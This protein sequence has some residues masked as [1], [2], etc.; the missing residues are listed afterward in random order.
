MKD[1]IT[2]EIFKHIGLKSKWHCNLKEVFALFLYHLICYMDSLF[3]ERFH[4]LREMFGVMNMGW[5]MFH[6]HYGFSKLGLYH[7]VKFYDEVREL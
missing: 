2:S 5:I 7:F 3:D 4:S 6:C 1:A